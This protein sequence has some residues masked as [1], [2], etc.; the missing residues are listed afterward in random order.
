MYMSHTH[1]YERMPVRRV[2]RVRRSWG[3][4]R[5]KVM[6]DRGER[7]ILYSIPVHMSETD[8]G[9]GPERKARR[10]GRGGGAGRSTHSVEE[11]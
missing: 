7:A 2:A 11:E 1:T 5:C 6:R 8:A 9:A 4:L 10:R 3:G